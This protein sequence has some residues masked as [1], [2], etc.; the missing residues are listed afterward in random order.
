M[1]PALEFPARLF[2]GVDG[3]GYLI[4]AT[5]LVLTVLYYRFSE[6]TSVGGT[7]ERFLDK[8]PH[9]FYYDTESRRFN[10][11]AD[12]AIP[13]EA[14][15]AQS[16][17]GGDQYTYDQVSRLLDSFILLV[18]DPASD[19]DGENLKAEIAMLVDPSYKNA[20]IAVTY[21][22][23][24]NNDKLQPGQRQFVYNLL[25]NYFM[26]VK[27]PTGVSLERWSDALLIC[28]FMT[29]QMPKASEFL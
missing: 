18:L 1:A 7:P 22:R 24:R 11:K 5:L 15:L 21:A 9:G 26:R 14:L 17:K 23:R 20:Y 3:R 29:R 2:T 16:A 10:T 13:I 12:R 19:E 25:V 6:S 27:N 8:S 4:L 28:T